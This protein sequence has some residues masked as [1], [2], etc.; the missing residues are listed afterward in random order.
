MKSLA[1]TLNNLPQKTRVEVVAL[2]NS[3]LA[4][5]IDLHSQTK[6]AHWNVR[7]PHFY[8]LHKLFDEL[9]ALVEAHIDPLAER[10]TALGGRALGTVRQAAKNSGLDEFPSVPTGELGYVVALAEPFSI[11]GAGVRK[12]IDTTA[13]AGD[14]D[15]ADLLTGL[16]QDLD[17][18][19]WLLE[20]H[21]RK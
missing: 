6:H 21:T 13:T 7:G 11:L 14:T 2:L 16:S 19:L 12:S 4:D 8:S 18:G 10:I 20:A 5:L 17:K 9:A 1:R 15:T 3:I